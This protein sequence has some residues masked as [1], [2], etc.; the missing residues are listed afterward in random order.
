MTF[1]NN[2][3][4]KLGQQLA[5]GEKL[6]VICDH[7]FIVNSGTLFFKMGSMSGLVWQYISCGYRGWAEGVSICRVRV[8]VREVCEQA[9]VE[10][11][12]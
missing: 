12:V 2:E 9:G 4:I 11:E 8:S 5:S 10:V 6:V 7:C 1:C 3:N